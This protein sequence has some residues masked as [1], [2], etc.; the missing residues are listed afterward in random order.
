M[1]STLC[2][3]YNKSPFTRDTWNKTLCTRLRLQ[4][5]SAHEHS[6]AHKDSMKLE[7]ET[8]TT[9]PIES[10]INPRI[11]AKGIEQAFI[12]LYFL[13]KQRIPHTTNYEPLLDLLGLL[14]LN[15]KSKIQVAKNA[16]YTS[17]KAIQEMIYIVSEV[18][19]THFERNEGV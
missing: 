14:G 15:V 3:K 9:R 5:I 19:E 2:Q 17:D 16:L 10:A 12:S 8:L 1:L 13:A 18:I 7:S 6:A 4:S 11:P